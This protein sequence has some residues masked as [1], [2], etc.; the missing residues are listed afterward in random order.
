VIPK[1]RFVLSVPG[2]LERYEFIRSLC[3]G[4]PFSAKTNPEVARV[5]DEKT[6]CYFSIHTPEGLGWV[7]DLGRVWYLAEGIERETFLELLGYGVRNFVID[8]EEDLGLLLDSIDEKDMHVNLLLRMRFQETTVYKGRYFLFGMMPER[9]NS[10]IPGLSKNPRIGKLGIHF[11]RKS[12]NTGNWSYREMLQEVLDGETLEAV[13][14]MNIGGGIPI[15]Y[16]NTGDSNMEYIV[17][18]LREL[19]EWLHDNDIKMVCE[20]GRPIAGPPVKLE[21]WI[22]SISGRNI[23]VNA[24]V[25]NSS[26]DTI[27]VPHKLLVE[28]ELSEGGRSY[29]IKG[30]TPCS[31]DIFRYDVL[32]ENPRVGDRITF[33]NAGAYNF[34]SSFCN[35]EKPR[36]VLV[37]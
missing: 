1:A 20:P 12:Q 5:L 17:Q 34:H 26:L 29:V 22:T 2:V 32:L 35:L 14:I 27:I 7:E 15:K 36:T 4:V 23:T 16:K 25:Y 31:M 8:N 18:K 21:T 11:H 10:L 30:C 24:S 3:D 13:D 37:D 9:I 28:G 19:R 33:L 6:D